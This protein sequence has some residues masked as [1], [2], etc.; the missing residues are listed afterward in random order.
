[1]KCQD[2]KLS[3]SPTQVKSLDRLPENQCLWTGE[4]RAPFLPR[5]VT[6]SFSM[7]PLG[8]AHFNEFEKKK[9]LTEV[10]EGFLDP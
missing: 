6:K 7:G 8:M 1:M 10:W 9:L 5:V 4:E 2:C 3:L